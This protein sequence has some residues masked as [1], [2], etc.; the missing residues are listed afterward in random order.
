MKC[1]E[2][3]EL[4]SHWLNAKGKGSSPCSIIDVREVQEYTQGHVPNAKLIVLNTVPIRSDEFPRD[5]DVYVICRSGI[6][7]AQAIKFLEQNDGYQNL[8]N[9]RGG[10]L[11]WMEEEYPIE[12]GE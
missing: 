10:I 3:H 8:I 7:S 6:R 9:I 1:I 12:Q 5:G 11:A 4:Y 2:A